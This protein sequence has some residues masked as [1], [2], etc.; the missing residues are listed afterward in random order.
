MISFSEAPGMHATTFSGLFM[1]F[2]TASTGAATMKVS[3]ISMAMS[4]S[5]FA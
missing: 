3:L 5:D 4:Y 1:N 2:H